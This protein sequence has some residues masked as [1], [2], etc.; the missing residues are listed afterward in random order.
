MPPLNSDGWPRGK[1]LMAAYEAKFGME[2]GIYGVGL[3]EMTNR[4]FEALEKAGDP[5]NR[6]AVAR[7]IGEIKRPTVA[8]NL[9]FDPATHVALQSNDHIPA[10]FW[11]LQAGGAR[12]LIE[13]GKYAKGDFLLPPWMTK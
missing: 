3:Y 10:S 8:G 2:S 1:E 7:A 9:E 12:M 6:E 5:T 11:Q 4:N 13:P